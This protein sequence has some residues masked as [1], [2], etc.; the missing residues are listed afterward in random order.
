M[1]QVSGKVGDIYGTFYA[2]ARGQEEMWRMLY[3]NVPEN[4]AAYFV[5]IWAGQ[6]SGMRQVFHT[7]R[8]NFQ[9]FNRVLHIV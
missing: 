8:E 3:G 6:C 2:S 4:G 9:L 1:T 7:A 5:K